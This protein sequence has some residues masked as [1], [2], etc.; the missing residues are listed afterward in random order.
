MAQDRL[1]PDLLDPLDPFELDDDNLAQLGKWD[2]LT[3]EDLLE[4]WRGEPRLFM[5]PESFPADWDLVSEVA[6]VGT[7]VVPLMSPKSGDKTKV[8]P[9]TMFRANLR[10][11]A[12]Y[13]T[14]L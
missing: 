3:R 8:R 14:Q 9:I 5:A 11:Q 7:I 4:A 13:L 2:G 10:T 12:R 6:S 1:D